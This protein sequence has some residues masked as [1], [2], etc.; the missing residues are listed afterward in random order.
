MSA[1][2]LI[3]LLVVLALPGFGHSSIKAAQG[4]ETVHIVYA[5]TSN[6]SVKLIQFITEFESYFP[7]SLMRPNE[8]SIVF[9]RVNG[10]DS[11]LR[12]RPEIPKALLD[13]LVEW[14]VPFNP[15]A[16]DTYAVALR[17]I[18]LRQAIVEE[19]KVLGN[20]NTRLVSREPWFH[21]GVKDRDTV[22]TAL[23]PSI[24]DFV[25]ASTDPMFDFD[26]L[27]SY[28]FYP[29]AARGRN[30]TGRVLVAA[31]VGPD[32]HVEDVVIL[33]STD[34]VY[35]LSA[36][37]AIKCLRFRPGQLHGGPARLWVRVPIEFRP[38]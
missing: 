18:P 4:V 10:K 17:V 34:P 25:S 27:G 13:S 30:M 2:G 35:D 1:R 21:R 14:L 23:R 31:L 16:V 5:R 11:V 22:R 6:A 7:V 32:G 20:P 9:R 8:L 24:N 38:G 12:T 3:T 26:R 37:R 19:S 28:I 29:A 36:A 33:E 15:M